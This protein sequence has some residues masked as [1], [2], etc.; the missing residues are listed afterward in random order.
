MPQVWLD[1]EE[2]AEFLSCSEEEARH[3]AVAHDWPRQVG[4]DDVLRFKLPPREALVYVLRNAAATPPRD[5]VLLERALSD[6]ESLRRQLHEAYA[7]IEIL[8]R[9]LVSVQTDLQV[10]AL[11]EL[12]TLAKDVA[13]VQGPVAE[14]GTAAA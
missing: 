2:L 7:K 6:A 13:G 11:Q 9:Q 14:R 1:K 5:A 4:V 10:A 12:S 3:A 8:E